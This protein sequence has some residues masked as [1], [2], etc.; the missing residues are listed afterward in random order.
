MPSFDMI[1]KLLGQMLGQIDN[2][3][4]MADAQRNITYMNASAEDAFGYS[5]EEVIGQPTQRLYLNADEFK[6]QGS[7]RFNEKGALNSEGTVIRYLC[8]NG[9]SFYGETVGGPIKDP[10]SDSVFMFGLIRDV[11]R[12]V[13]TEQTLHSLHAITSSRDLDF[14]DRIDAL[15]HLGC[16]HF[17][18]PI[19]IFSRIDGDQYVVQRA[20]HPE[21]LLTPGLSFSLSE[22][23]CDHVYKADNV[24][25]FHN[26]GKSEIRHHPCYASFNLEAYIGAPVIVDGERYG[27][28]NFSSADTVAPFTQQDVELVRLIALW[29]GHEVARFNDIKA[30][31]EAHK[32]L[33]KVAITDPLT[34]LANRR[35]AQK[36]LDECLATL[37]Q[38]TGTVCVALLDF[39]HFKQ[40]NDQHGHDAGDLA[41]QHLAT[42]S[43]DFLLPTDTLARWGGEEFLAILPDA[44][45][46]DAATR[47]NLLR[48]AVKDSQIEHNGRILPISLSIGLTMATPE[49]VSS[50]DEL[51]AR[52]DE[53]MYAAKEAGRNCLKML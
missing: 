43:H 8:K 11:S 9:A 22:T 36:V 48:Q 52:S 28:F 19:G 51:I 2:I 29:A 41:L 49:D 40:I 23:Y 4:L 53:A 32:A 16:A 10:D 26:V 13:T 3:I 50:R 27:T 15:L 30:L 17:G 18:L 12:R 44:L 39:D 31:E 34:G 46:S 20:C 45:T 21:G 42:L 38:S 25:A 5:L 14:D 33:E 35:H 37:A 7:L 6:R 47:I 24:Q 1:Q